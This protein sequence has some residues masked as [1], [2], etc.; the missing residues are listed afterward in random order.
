MWVEVSVGVV[1]APAPPPSPPICL[2]RLDGGS[3]FEDLADQQ[4]GTRD[5]ICRVLTFA[6]SL[7]YTVSQ[8]AWETVSG[9][10]LF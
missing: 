6:S 2:K 8:R 3:I 7:Q 5:E 9:R 10:V 1:P 4:G